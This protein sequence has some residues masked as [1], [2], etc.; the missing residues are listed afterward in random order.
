LGQALGIVEV[1]IAS[2]AAVRRAFAPELSLP[3]TRRPTRGNV[4]TIALEV[5]SESGK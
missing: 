3:S 4:D 5:I 1:F 2:Q